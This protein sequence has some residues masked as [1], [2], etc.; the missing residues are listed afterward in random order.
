MIG[1]WHVDD[2]YKD[3][4]DSVQSK[5]N[6][7]IT[8]ASSIISFYGA[9]S[10][11]MILL[12][13]YLM[14]RFP[15]APYMPENAINLFLQNQ[16]KLPEFIFDKRFQIGIAVALYAAKSIFVSSK[17][18]V[19]FSEIIADEIF[20]ILSFSFVAY[21]ILKHTNKFDSNILKA[22][23]LVIGI[24]LHSGSKAIDE[25]EKKKLPKDK[26]SSNIMLVNDVINMMVQ[27]FAIVNLISF[28]KLGSMKSLSI[29][30]AIGFIGLKYVLD[31]SMKFKDITRNAEKLAA[32]ISNEYI[33]AEEI[34]EMNKD[35]IKS[36]SIYKLIEELNEIVKISKFS[37]KEEASLF[38][39]KII[40]KID[41]YPELEKKHQFVKSLKSSAKGNFTEFKDVAVNKFKNPLHPQSIIKASLIKSE[42]NTGPL[43]FISQFIGYDGI[44]R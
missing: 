37:N 40:D 11:L 43:S 15:G 35:K 2:N 20:P 42:N 7:I 24:A 32:K 23:S 30:S 31:Y 4:I 26:K 38:L 9:L 41:K 21:F 10:Y 25:N 33:K 3:E 28:M 12:K 17:K 8:M 14:S 34:I 29:V 5:S 22:A 13:K 39:N 16:Y 36:G 27:I 44:I 1:S 18:W 19:K 6:T